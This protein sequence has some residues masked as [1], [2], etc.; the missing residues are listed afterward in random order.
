M[1]LEFDTS[2]DDTY[3]PSLIEVIAQPP[4]RHLSSQ[5][6]LE[7]IVNII[8]TMLLVLYKSSKKHEHGMRAHTLIISHK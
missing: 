4:C 6:R 8:V 3:Q 2:I 7:C 1:V 5:R